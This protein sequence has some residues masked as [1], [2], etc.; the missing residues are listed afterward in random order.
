M[1]PKYNRRDF[2]RQ[3]SATL[4][5][6]AAGAAYAADK[7]ATP[8]A[9]NKPMKRDYKISL[10]MWSFHR[11][12][13]T[14]PGKLSM[15][16]V[17][18]MAADRYDI[19]GLEL[20]STMLASTEKSYLDELARN[21][22]AAKSQLLLI[23]ID[24]QGDIGSDRQSARDLA[25]TNHSRWID[26]AADFGCHSI[27]MNWTGAPKNVYEDAAALKDFTDRSVPGFRALCDYGDKKNVN[28]IIENHGGASSHIDPLVNLMK[29]VDHP[30]FGT[31]PDFGNFPD[32]VDKYAAIDAFMPYAKALSA[33]CHDFDDQTG[34]E[35][36]IDFEK[37]LQIAVDKHGYNSWI[38]IEYEGNRLGEYEGTAAANTLLLK[39]RG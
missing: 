39:L 38:G 25:V 34:L 9:G 3:T 1:D 17:P 10:A 37:M 35:T 27:R 29:A 18:K 22:A 26:I 28:V 11:T 21:A 14:Q 30:R 8:A 12:V 19:H 5:L 32:D 20:V 15:L 2:L 4:A 13:G 23:M 16:D 24:G 33:K 6:G 31:L 7:A 36:K